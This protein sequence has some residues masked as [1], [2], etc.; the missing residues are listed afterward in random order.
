MPTPTVPLK[1]AIAT[2]LLGFALVGSAGLAAA[3]TQQL[4]QSEMRAVAKAC[5]NDV[6]T[7]CPGIQPGGGRIGQCLQQNAER[8][9]APCKQTLS[10]VLAK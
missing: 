8:V 7:L 9:S 4:S 6:K 1:R 2:A 10:E 3:Q 5:K